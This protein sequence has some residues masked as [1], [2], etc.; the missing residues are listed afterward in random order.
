MSHVATL[1][2]LVF[3]QEQ[4]RQ[5]WKGFGMSSW[6]IDRRRD[7]RATD[8]RWFIGNGPFPQPGFQERLRNLATKL[9]SLRNVQDLDARIAHM[10]PAQMTEQVEKLNAY[11]RSR[12][13]L[14]TIPYAERMKRVD[15]PLPAP[16]SMDLLTRVTRGM[17]PASGSFTRSVARDEAMLQN[18]KGLTIVR[19]WQL[20]HNGALPPSLADAAKEAGLP[21]V[22]LDPY[23]AQPIRLGIIDGQ[24][25]VYC[26]GEDGRDD[27]G[28]KDSTRTP[29]VGDVLLLLPKP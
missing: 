20:R 14:G 23:I 25:V 27:H 5:A 12:M 22:P 8:G 6:S 3:H 16:S 21:S 26:V 7:C 15:E 19:R 9:M 2:D 17:L 1:R 28:K 10:T 13:A 24:P 4:V 11:Y 29:T 18:A